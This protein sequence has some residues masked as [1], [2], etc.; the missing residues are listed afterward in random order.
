MMFEMKV[1]KP[2][3]EDNCEYRAEWEVPQGTELTPGTWFAF[4]NSAHLRTGMGWLARR[5]TEDQYWVDKGRK[6]LPIKKSDGYEV[7]IDGHEGHHWVN[8][9]EWNNDLKI[10]IAIG[11]PLPAGKY[12]AKIMRTPAP[13]GGDKLSGC[14]NPYEEMAQPERPIN[15]DDMRLAQAAAN[16]MGSSVQVGTTEVMP[17]THEETQT[18]IAR[19]RAELDKQRLDAAFPDNQGAPSKQS[20]PI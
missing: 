11:E 17:M 10:K 7:L 19:L 8:I 13:W 16:G 12:M 5:F 2:T 14:I 1:F 9:S 20:L 4:G 15:Q 18:E 6:P 3:P